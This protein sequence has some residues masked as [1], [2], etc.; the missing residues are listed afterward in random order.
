METDVSDLSAAELFFPIP[1]A[2]KLLTSGVGYVVDLSKKQSKFFEE[3]MAQ[4]P[5]SPIPEA[6]IKDISASGELSIKFTT[7]LL[8]P[9][10]TKE[11]IQAQIEQN[12]L[13]IAAGEPTDA[14][15]YIQ[16]FAVS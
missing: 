7:N 14:A 13:K 2:T 3:A 1:L 11:K 6:R 16:V 8:I 15:S 5:S 10:G 12:S 9:D 4:G